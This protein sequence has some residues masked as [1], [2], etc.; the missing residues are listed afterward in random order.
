M[1]G[2]MGWD[3]F[4]GLSSQLLASAHQAK[5]ERWQSVAAAAASWTHRPALIH[6]QP[7]Q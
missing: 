2:L 6:V 3:G 1:L 7:E 5:A 4:V